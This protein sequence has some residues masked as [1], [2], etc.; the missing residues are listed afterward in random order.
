MPDL[1]FRTSRGALYGITTEPGILANAGLKLRSVAGE[2]DQAV[3]ITDHKVEALYSED[4]AA[5]LARAG[6][7]TEVLAIEPGEPSKSLP[8]AISLWDRLVDLGF[9]R[10]GILIAFGGGVVTDLTGFVA[11]AFMRGV[12]YAN[13]PTTLLAQA[14]TPRSA[15]RSV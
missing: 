13:M 12:G 14:S 4:L 6:F 1:L 15:A 3:I 5:S 9:R 11:A 2:A 8:V 10:R 7:Q